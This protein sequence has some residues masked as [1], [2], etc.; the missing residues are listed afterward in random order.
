MESLEWLGFFSSEKLGYKETTPFEITSDRMINKMLLS[1]NE[2]DMVIMQHI[3]L[4]SYPD[5]KKEVIRSSMLDFGSPVTNTAI[6][7]TVALP[8]AIAVKLILDNKIKLTGVYRPVVP[9]I[10][11]PVLDELKKLG[12]EMKEE[13]GL[14]ESTPLPRMKR[15]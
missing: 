2:R 14:P 10:Y 8:A 9:E 12:I 1:D 4:A 7:R 11:I 5:R 3:F 15:N 13:F 6:A